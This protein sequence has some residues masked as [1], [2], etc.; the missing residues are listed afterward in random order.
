MNDTDKNQKALE[1]AQAA[2]DL[3]AKHEPVAFVTTLPDGRILGR[4]GCGVE[5]AADAPKEPAKVEQAAKDSGN[6]RV[7]VKDAGKDG[8]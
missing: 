4:C 7:F 6:R 1:T 3:H 5:L 2:N 8:E